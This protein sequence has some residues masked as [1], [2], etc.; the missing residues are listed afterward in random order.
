MHWKT[1]ALIR[2]FAKWRKRFELD[3]LC[4]NCGAQGEARVSENNY[5][6]MRDPGFR[7]DEY[8]EGFSGVRQSVY[9]HETQVRCSCGQVFYL[10]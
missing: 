6:S 2:M 1:D 3:I 5:P 8:P 10:L 4:P 7:V 9:L